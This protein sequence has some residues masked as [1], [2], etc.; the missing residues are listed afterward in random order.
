MDKLAH[1]YGAVLFENAL[2]EQQAPLIYDQISDVEAILADQEIRDFFNAKIVPTSQKQQLLTESLKGYRP[3][4]LNLLLMVI[5]NDHLDLLS[6]ITQSYQEQYE[7]L[8]AQ[9]R[10]QVRSA[11][12]L[13]QAQHQSLKKA[14]DVYFG[15]DVLLEVTVDS[16]L[17]QGLVVQVGD[18]ILDKSLRKN[19][20]ELEEYLRKGVQHVA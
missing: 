20:K 8:Q 2:Q 12:H 5:K 1:R 13:D 11:F 4:I 18:L 9:R 15:F 19:L 6:Q 10:V 7:K 16:S 14:L 3:E 17:I